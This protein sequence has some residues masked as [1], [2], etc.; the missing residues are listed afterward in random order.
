MR[1][2]TLVLAGAMIAAS[3]GT[4]AIADDKTDAM[5]TVKQFTDSFNKGDAKAVIASCAPQTII[6]D[7]FPPHVWQGT[8]TCS[9]WLSAIGAYD[10]QQGIANEL[11]TLRKA[12][13]V[14]ITGDRGYVVVPTVYTYKQNG[15]PVTEAGSIW[16]LALQK[17]GKIWQITGWAW[18]QH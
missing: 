14:T 17:A 2:V 18:G 7:D 13:H 3:L 9:D 16:T 8:S 5:S 11:V 6:I 15:K 4:Q 10:K 1:T 12:W